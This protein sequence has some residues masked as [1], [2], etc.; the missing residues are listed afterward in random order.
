MSQLV[1]LNFR[2]DART[3]RQFGFIATVG[4]GLLALAAWREWLIFSAGLGEW[5]T[6]VS[7]SLAALGAVS[8]CFSLVYPKANW[9]IFVGLSIVGCHDPFPKI[10]TARRRVCPRRLLNRC[11]KLAAAD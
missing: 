10:S 11:V 4:F 9:P 5:R 2:P 8:L 7:G 6:V 3:L 1:E